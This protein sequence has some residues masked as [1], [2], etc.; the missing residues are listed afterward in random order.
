DHAV[1]DSARPALVSVGRLVGARADAVRNRVRRLPRVSGGGD[2]LPDETVELGKTRAVAGVVGRGGEDFE[3][4][5]EEAVVLGS[6]GSGTDVFR[7]VAPVAVGADPALEE[8]RLV[9]L[10]R[11]V[12]GG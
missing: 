3:E 10:D 8:L 6:E 12:P 2:A 1:A 5:V 7:V 4:L 9:L 11:P